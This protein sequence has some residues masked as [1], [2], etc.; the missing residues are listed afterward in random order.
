MQTPGSPF[1]WTRSLPGVRT[2]SALWLL[3]AVL[4]GAPLAFGG[5]PPVTV[6]L[7]AV[8]AAA[9][10]T[11]SGVSSGVVSRDPALKAWGVL[12]AVSALH[13]TPL[14]P[15]LLRW[16][17][18]VSEAASR[19]AWWPFNID[20][21]AAWRPLH[22]DPGAGLSDFVYLLGLGALYLA[23]KRVAMRDG[24]PVL[25]HLTAAATLVVS[26]LAAAHALTGQDR[27]YGFYAPVGAAP[28]VLSPLLNPNHLA[29]MAAAGCVLWLGRAVESNRGITRTA[30]GLAAAL[31]GV[32]CAMTLS[33]GGV[34]AG[35]GGVAIFAALN[36]RVITD[37][38]QPRELR[39]SADARPWVGV[40]LGASIVGA[41]LYLASASL[42]REY[43]SGDT[44][45]I[46]NIRRALGLL[47]GHELLGVG[48]GG[49][50]A[51]VAALGKLDPEW[52]FLR[53]E[54]LP[55]DL[56][57]AFGVPAAAVVLALGVQALRQWFP[58]RT[59]PASTLATWCALLVLLLHDLMDFSLFLGGVGYLAAALAGLL[60]AQRARGW[61]KPLPRTNR[62][63]RLPGF[64]AL[65]L[66]LA[67]FKATAHAP[68][69]ADRDRLE[70]ALRAEPSAYTSPTV[71][72]AFAR[73]PSDAYTRLL[74][75]SYAISAGDRHAL[76]YIA[77][78]LELAP[79]WAQPH[80]MLARFFAARGLR[81]QALL[82]TREA[83]VRSR[84]VVGP[85]AALVASLEPLPDRAELERT[86][87]RSPSGLA[88]L[89]GVGTRPG[90]PE[91]FGE[92]AD[93]LLL[94]RD[95][96]SPAALQRRARARLL[97]ADLAGSEA[98]CARFLRAWPR[99]PR[100]PL[101]LASVERRRQNPT[102]ALRILDQ[103]ALRV[104][105][106]FP[107]L[108]ERCHIFAALGDVAAMRRA[109]DQLLER[110]GAD[111]DRR[112]MA[113][114]LRGRFEAGFGNDR[115]ALEAFT[116]A[117]S[118]AVPEHPYLLELAQVA[119]RLRDRQ[120]LE[121]ACTVLMEQREQD[122]SVEPLCARGRAPG[123]RSPVEPPAP[124]PLG[125]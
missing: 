113:H 118:L 92:L 65:G 90:L 29:A 14:P 10:L 57:L 11:V 85:L 105:D 101:C 91:A 24:L 96:V 48:S 86:A 66:L 68:P 52:T 64:L 27:L 37:N 108:L 38:T 60:A 18:P 20:R 46:E 112:I 67:L 25:Q 119:A 114:G 7:F 100:G 22:Y 98:L 115:R 13:L 26:G 95:A 8:L 59:A 97:A 41:G 78:A 73:H 69:E 53:I 80:V 61:K 79:S 63:Y 124:A 9:A 74:V 19:W 106:P 1:A 5:A 116:L 72:A 102:Q 56:A 109:T 123:A 16:I 42:A 34:A 40:L 55:A 77:R 3:G 23:S 104:T 31:C 6:P 36:L 110:A 76:R 15:G 35:V 94:E 99:D 33:R 87:P 4:L 120:V 62:V 82:E 30:E 103:G 121:S 58:P 122:P 12:L 28:P 84:T 81:S 70:R 50:N 93:T 111:L 75:G 21:A 89:E 51:A 54:S 44:S 71:R 88:F 2:R 83:L 47:R 49:L 107:L 45:K 125:P 17:D 43:Q 32:V 39:A 117:E